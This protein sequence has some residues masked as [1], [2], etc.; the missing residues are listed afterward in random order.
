MH[1]FSHQVS[2]KDQLRTVPI[3]LLPPKPLENLTVQ[4][5]DFRALARRRPHAYDAVVTVFFIDTAENIFAYLDAI[6][7]LLKDDGVWINYGP[8]KWGSAPL[9]ELTLLEIVNAVKLHGWELVERFQGEDNY[10]GDSKCMWKGKYQ[11][12]GWVAKK[13]QATKAQSKSVQTSTR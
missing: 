8:L 5:G 13:K 7:A 3:D 10:T 2:G 11:I 9:A 6:D 4:Y 12:R 1:Q